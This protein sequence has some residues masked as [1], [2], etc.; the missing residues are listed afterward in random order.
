[1]NCRTAILNGYAHRVIVYEAA[2]NGAENLDDTALIDI[3]LVSASATP[4][5]PQFPHAT[6]ADYR[7]DRT[8]DAFDAIYAIDFV[9]SG[10]P[11]P[12]NP[13]Q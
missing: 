6:R 8:L 1:L 5:D 10:G 12:C 9:F 4:V 2:G 11:P 7:Y 3:A 13:C